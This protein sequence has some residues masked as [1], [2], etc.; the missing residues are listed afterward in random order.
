MQAYCR[1]ST[2]TFA[3]LWARAA[4]LHVFY[5]FYNTHVFIRFNFRYL[6]ELEAELDSH[7]RRFVLPYEKGLKNKSCFEY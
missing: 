5:F 6:D 2:D 1:P 4:Q 3:P 7:A